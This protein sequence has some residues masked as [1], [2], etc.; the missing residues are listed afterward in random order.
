MPRSCTGWQ[1]L[2]DAMEGIAFVVD[3]SGLVVAAGSRNWNAFARSNGAPELDAS[4]VV[5]RALFD[6]VSGGDVRRKLGTL[7]TR[8]AADPNGSTVIP[9]RCD[10]PGVRRNLR[11][12]IRPIVHDERCTGFVF[13]SI[14]LE[15]RERPPIDLFDFRA[16]ARRAEREASLPV[17]VMC[18]WCQRVRFPPITDGDW[19]DAE[20]YYGAGG[21]SEVSLSHSICDRCETMVGSA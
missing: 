18:S 9:F 3:R 13:Q 5:G 14:E 21:G 6:F 12:S 17:V 15:A 11:Q 7:M 20:A 8:I 19:Y 4:A 2:L 1:S 10:S 16:I